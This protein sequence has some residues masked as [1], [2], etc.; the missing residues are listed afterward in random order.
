MA[1]WNDLLDT[2]SQDYG[3]VGNAVSGAID[4][5]GPTAARVGYALNP[6]TS[7][8]ALP[9]ELRTYLRMRGAEKPAGNSLADQIAAVRSEVNRLPAPEE[10]LMSV[11]APEM[12][13]KDN[14]LQSIM[15][16]ANDAANGKTVGPNDTVQNRQGSFSRSAPAIAQ[17]VTAADREQAR[18]IEKEQKKAE[19]EGRAKLAEVESLARNGRETEKM[20]NDYDLIKSILSSPSEAVLQNPT[21]VYEDFQAKMQGKDSETEIN[22]RAKEAE[23]ATKK[24]TPSDGSGV[25]GAVALGGAAV[26]AAYLIKRGMKPKEAKAIAEA[27]AGKAKAVGPEVFKSAMSG[28]EKAAV[29]G[30]AELAN[31]LPPRA[32]AASPATMMRPRG[33]RNVPSDPLP[34]TKSELRDLINT[35]TMKGDQ[36]MSP[37]EYARWERIIKA[38]GAK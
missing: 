8:V 3:T 10:A 33:P 28:T 5:Y 1:T 29:D 16:W 27:A 38:Y 6:V 37:E 35:L 2:I 34:A 24:K 18:E 7:G 22:A 12:P 21:Q 17:Y 19:A 30:M 23:A 4:E 26:L 31:K 13:W 15:T 11:E 14:N 9:L 36:G 25:G 32:V 20:R